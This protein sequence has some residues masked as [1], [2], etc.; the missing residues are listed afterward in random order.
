MKQRNASEF[1]L[2]KKE[3][4]N[5]IVEECL[6]NN[7][8]DTRQIAYILGTAQH[9]SANF[10]R[11]R[12]IGGAAQAAKLGYEGGA[13]YAGRGF[14]QLTH[15][16]NYERMDEKLGLKGKLIENPELAADP[17]IAA[18]I[19]VVGM[20]DG[21]FTGKPISK[22]INADAEDYTGARRVVNGVLKSRPETIRA[23]DLCGTYARQWEG[24]LDDIIPQ[25]RDPRLAGSRLEPLRM[26]SFS[27]GSLDIKGF[28]RALNA[29]G[30]RD[31]NGKPLAVDGIVGRHTAAAIT[32]FQRAQGLP[33]N[34]KL[35]ERTRE[36]L[37]EQFDNLRSKDYSLV[38][39]IRE[40][41]HGAQQ[42]LGKGW[43][44]ASENISAA[45]GV[46]AKT[47]GFEKADAV[48]FS[49]NL[50]KV[51]ILRSGPGLTGTLAYVVVKE[52]MEMP[53]GTSMT[54]MHD[55]GTYAR[56]VAKEFGDMV[57]PS[58]QQ[59]RKLH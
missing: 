36:M 3:S 46:V 1:G 7:V 24:K 20:R 49:K 4:V 52:A 14:V 51:A 53:A 55:L 31:E 48:E 18:R 37:V 26:P 42:K 40:K 47:A 19:L 43:D 15:R 29:T 22:Y 16:S 8:T 9:E 32:E 27:S 38:N 5:L 30:F 28:Q 34:G 13:N 45:L 12:E 2:T 59:Q 35:S 23:A 44:Q 11:A 10:T 17:R 50:A 41:L 54:N 33:A 56:S 6:R 58:L 57:I 39:G 25:C 21:M